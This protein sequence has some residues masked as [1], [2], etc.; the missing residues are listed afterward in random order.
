MA[1]NYLS[2]LAPRT[3]G[4]GTYFVRG[5]LLLLNEGLPHGHDIDQSPFQL[6]CIL[7]EHA[8]NFVVVKVK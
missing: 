5:I 7:S 8:G 3:M 4:A 1:T 2:N 6:E